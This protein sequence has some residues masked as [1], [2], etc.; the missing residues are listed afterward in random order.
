MIDNR[1]KITE[2]EFW[3]QLFGGPLLGFAVYEEIGAAV[4][5]VK[6]IERVDFDG[7]RG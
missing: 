4:A 6:G 1:G 2:D 5:N 7:D 3:Q